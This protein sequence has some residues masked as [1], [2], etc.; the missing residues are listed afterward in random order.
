MAQEAPSIYDLSDGELERLRQQ[1][2]YAVIWG[3][4]A[5]DPELE[6]IEHELARRARIREQHRKAEVAAARERAW[7]E[8]EERQARRQDE[9]AAFLA[10]QEEAKR[11]AEERQRAEAERRRQDEEERRRA[12]E[13]RRRQE[14]ERLERELQLRRLAGDQVET[15][16]ALDVAVK[17]IVDLASNYVK[18]ERAMHQ[19]AVALGHTGGP[20]DD[21]EGGGGRIEERFTR[22]R[23]LLGAY[24]RAHLSAIPSLRLQPVTGHGPDEPGGTNGNRPSLEDPTRRLL[25]D[26]LPEPGRSEPGT[27]E[28]PSGSPPG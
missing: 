4:V 27:S 22:A 28:D 13:E 19:L 24:L 21:D 25:E 14:A 2:A 3:N 23:D 1:R 11:Q 6:Q 7:K 18:R 8:V 5:A 10:A 17:R 12:E 15:A 9:E 26:L 16:K 20:D